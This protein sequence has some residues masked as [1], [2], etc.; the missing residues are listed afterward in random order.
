MAKVSDHFKETIQNKL[1]EMAEDDPLFAENLEKEDKDI[2][3]CI[4]YILS[5]VKKIGAQGYTD[6]EIFGLAAHYYDEDDLEEAD[7]IKCNVV[8]NHKP[9]L[10]EEEKEEYREKARQKI[11]REERERM[12]SAGKPKTKPKKKQEEEQA[13]LF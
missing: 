1:Q 12:R 6:E 9:E 11:L 8:V 13:S 5:E 2:D 4:N 3:G 7:P 10:T